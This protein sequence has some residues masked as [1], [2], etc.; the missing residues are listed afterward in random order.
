MT[1]KNKHILFF[2]IDGTL[3]QPG[4]EVDKDTVDSI[5]RARENGNYILLNTGRSNKDIPEHIKAIG[6]DGGVYSGGGK[7]ILNDKVLKEEFLDQDLLLTIMNLLNNYG[8]SYNMEGP[9]NNYSDEDFEKLMLGEVD[10][11]FSSELVKAIK[12]SEDVGM[13]KSLPVSE[14]TDEPIYKINFRVFND[15]EEDLMKLLEQLDERIVFTSFDNMFPDSFVRAAELSP[16]T[17]DK[18][19]AIREVA[20]ILGIPIENTVAF[21][22]SSNDYEMIKEAGIGVAMG[23]SSEDVKEVATFVTDN[24]GEGGIKNALIKLNL[25]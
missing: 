20:N 16:N 8:F 10:L 17:H 12:S 3:A 14:Y 18:G 6:F 22:D 2:D 5:R 4:R 1:T 19:T 15:Q 13:T 24:C 21:G 25:I 11:G 7:I 23:N 9:N